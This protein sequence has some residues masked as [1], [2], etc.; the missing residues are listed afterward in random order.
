MAFLRKNI[1][2]KSK[3]GQSLYG[4][5]ENDKIVLMHDPY[6]VAWKMKSKGK[7]IDETVGHFPKELSQAAWFFLQRGGKISGNVSEEKYG[8][9]PI[10][11]GGLEIILE[12][13]LKIEDEKNKTS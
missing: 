1:M 7:L 2:Q 4:E 9:S 8:P 11:K 12:V 10:P 6:A 13:E 3:K 5:K